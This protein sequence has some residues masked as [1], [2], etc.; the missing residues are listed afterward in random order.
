MNCVPVEVPI[1]IY[2]GGTFDKSYSLKTGVAPDLVDI[3]LT[4]FTGSGAI[5]DKL[6]SEVPLL[7]LPFQNSIWE[8]DGPTGIYVNSLEWRIYINNEDTST[9][10]ADKK[11]IVGV[12]NVFLSNSVGEAVFKQFGEAV[13]VASV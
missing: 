4:D 11:N 2:Q 6:K 3:V 8:A 1:I 10:C 9:L 5:K 7:E 12:Y 13:I